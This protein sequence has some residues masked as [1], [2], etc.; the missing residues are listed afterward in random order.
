MPEYSC[1]NLVRLKDIYLHSSVVES[2]QENE[3]ECLTLCQREPRQDC[4]TN[5]GVST[6][7][8]RS[9]I[10]DSAERIHTQNRAYKS[11]KL[12]VLQCLEP[13][14]PQNVDSSSDSM[15]QTKWEPCVVLIS[16]SNCGRESN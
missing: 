2:F 14:R 13:S 15:L 10:S 11:P 16:I 9:W 4:V 3:F 7:K 1:P 8:W 5:C 12:E 6:A